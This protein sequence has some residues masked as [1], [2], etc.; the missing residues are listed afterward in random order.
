MK[1][2]TFLISIPLLII[3]SLCVLVACSQSEVQHI[4]QNTY[5]QKEN[6][7]E[8]TCSTKGQYDLVKYCSDCNSEV[9][10]EI[11]DLPASAH[12]A[13]NNVCSVCNKTAS[14]GLEYELNENDAYTVVGLGTCTDNQIIIPTHYNG[15]PVTTIG[16]R[17][18]YGATG[19]YAISCQ[20]ELERIE[21]YAFEECVD[22][23][24][25]YILSNVKSL[26][27]GVF[28]GCTKLDSLTFNSA[29]DYISSSFYGC[30]LLRKVN[31]LGD[32]N[33]WAQIYFYSNPTVYSRDLYINGNL[34]TDLVLDD[35]TTEISMNAFCY[36]KSLKTVKLP[37]NL[38]KVGHGTFYSN[39]P[40]LELNEYD[41]ALYLGNDTNKYLMLVKAKDDSISSCKIH[42]DT[43][44]IGSFAFYRCYG[45]TS[46]ELPDGLL[47][48]G[49]DSFADCVKI[50]NLVI[51]ESVEY[52][53]NY[54]FSDTGLKNV[55]FLPSHCEHAYSIFSGVGFDNGGLEVEIGANVTVIPGCMFTH[56]GGDS[57]P[58]NIKSLTFEKNS[59]CTEIEYNAFHDCPNAFDVYYFD[60][61]EQWNSIFVDYG[62]EMLISANKHFE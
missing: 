56:S 36:L 2:K 23:T 35:S 57:R 30:E 53:D 13:S 51:P 61:K 1:F 46:I 29:V 34:L 39:C 7:I 38:K 58:A 21:G 18:F 45:L 42:P 62:N 49:M 31:F 33:E 26:L 59:K 17:A 27:D 11:V 10:R 44:I 48:I 25:V 14:V 43:K 5:Y 28:S 55:T 41:N 20:L 9:G 4:H 37:E 54:A 32:V 47:F 3:I 12:T 60:S 15:K 24:S 52:I 40:N 22:L 6:V 19:I 8:P 50:T 16:R